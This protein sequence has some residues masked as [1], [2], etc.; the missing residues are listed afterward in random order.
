MTWDTMPPWGIK[1]ALLAAA[2]LVAAGIYRTWREGRTVSLKTQTPALVLRLLL[3][4]CLFAILIN[5]VRISLLSGQGKQKL[6]ILLDRSSS[7]A[8]NDVEGESRIS[9]ALDTLKAP[10]TQTRFNSAFNV[11]FRVFDES[12]QSA[13]FNNSQNIF[14]NGTG[15]HIQDVLSKAV[16][17]L[18]EESGNA[19][20]L[21]VSDGI[22]THGDPLNAAQLALAR[23]IPVWTWTLGGDVAPKD[24]WIETPASELMV[25]AGD[26]VEITATLS[27]EGF[28]NQGFIMEFVRDGETLES[29]EV[30]PGPGK[31]QTVSIQVK[32]PDSGEQRI[33]IRT[34]P[35]EGEANTV[36]NQRSV[37]LRAVGQKV[38]VLVVEGQ[39]HWDT[40]FLVQALKRHDRVDLTAVYRLG[41]EKYSAV[42]SKQ[43]TF[44]REDANLFPQT[45][46]E[47]FNYDICVFG[48]NCD[49]FFLDQ[50]EEWLTRFVA[51]KGGGLIFSRGRPYNGRFYP[52]AK[53]EPVVWGNG[54]Q[55]DILPVVT[56]QGMDCPV[57]DVTTATGVNKLFSRMPRLDQ[58][59]NT[60]GEKPLATVLAMSA[61]GDAQAARQNILI[62][63]QRFGQGRV[64][65]M[66]STGMWRW[67]FREKTTEEEEQVF[68]RYWLSMFRWLLADSD[69]LPGANTSL[70]SS[71][72]YYSEGEQME[73]RIATRGLDPALYQP[74]LIFDGEGTHDMFEPGMEQGGNAYVRAGPFE[75][76]TY[77]ITLENNVGSPQ[78]QSTTVEV[79]RST[80]EAR[81]LSAN[82][83]LMA[84][85]SRE[86]DGLALT[87]AEVANL[88]TIIRKW[89]I[90]RSQPGTKTRLW[91]N[92]LFLLVMLLILG[93]E[94]YV[95]RQKGLF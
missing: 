15:T 84:R 61:S 87:K 90:S 69:F 57:F 33:V 42:V 62:A 78:T 71:S 54:E 67:A 21:L 23:S 65:T 24:V 48:R 93:L 14:P 49:A 66:N 41:P 6:V 68:N 16:E 11:D 19:G 89:E 1:G 17:D 18:K 58:A 64:V 12:T 38:R 63:Y 37:F 56:P 2:L 92:W 95:R 35:L 72:R 46:E 22:S 26:N 29:K 34:S 91:D 45:E 30:Y 60:V 88:P 47:L 36:N 55:E 43:G 73:F 3:I 94:W 76:G 50:T 31:K 79:L 20:I 70:R 83:E 80:V 25:F 74:R 7:M 4:A 53:F 77:R 9:Q 40:K 81:N 5:P 86:S 75:P 8:I 10:D 13:D 59:A 44:K 52:L 82:P 32:A 39:P 27:Q 28:V 51:E 85:I